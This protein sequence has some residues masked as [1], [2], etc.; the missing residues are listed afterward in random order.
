MNPHKPKSYYVMSFDYK[1]ENGGDEVFVAYTVPYTYTQMQSHF[2]QIRE[3]A[4]T[5]PFQFIKFSS[6]GKS[7]GGVDMPLLKITN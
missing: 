7:N 2:R 3:V 5:S 4:E 6:I 1:F